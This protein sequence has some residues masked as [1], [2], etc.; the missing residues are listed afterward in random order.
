MN[1]VTDSSLN[2]QHWRITRISIE[3]K[4]SFP[5]GCAK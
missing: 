5:M 4:I 2:L 1:I 3:Y